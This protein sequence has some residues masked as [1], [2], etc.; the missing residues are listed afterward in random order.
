MATRRV[1]EAQS[2]RIE[3]VTQ[4]RKSLGVENVTTLRTIAN[5]STTYIEQGNYKKVEE[6][7]S[8][9]LQIRQRMLPAGYADTVRSIVN[10]SAVLVHQGR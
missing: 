5:L 1:E 3:L 9:V 4:S 6:L 10:L 8:E 2:L 7:C